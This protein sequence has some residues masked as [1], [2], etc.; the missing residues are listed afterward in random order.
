MKENLDN[1]ERGPERPPGTVRLW[2][3]VRWLPQG[4]VRYFKGILGTE[5]KLQLRRLLGGKISKIPVSVVEVQDGRRFKVGPSIAYW[6][7]YYTNDYESE[8]TALLRE[9]LNPGDTVLDV[10]ANI[11]WYSTLCALL[12]GEAGSVFAFEPVPSNF[13]ALTENIR[14][15]AMEKSISAHRVAVGDENG[16]IEVHSFPHQVGA[17]SLSTLGRD[18]Y[19]I[20]RAPMV[21]LDDFLAQSKIDAVHCVKCDVEGAELMVLR[22][23]KQL[24]SS[25]NAPM[26]L[27]ELNDET[28]AYFGFDRAQV[29]EVLK[30]YGYDHFLI[31]PAPFRVKKVAD[32]LGLGNAN[33]LFAC[34]GSYAEDRLSRRGWAIE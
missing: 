13:D 21:A 4:L 17:D 22:G 29:L 9:L 27:I 28:G 16:E 25:D 31:I 32:T 2:W 19:S 24:F 15:N 6:S 5:T 12:T 26:V 20:S 3:V 33:M 1:S 7:I 34:K 30:S 23:G 18:N 11:G 8:C 14:L 10:G